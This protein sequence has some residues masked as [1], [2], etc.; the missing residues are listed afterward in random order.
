VQSCGANINHN[1]SRRQIRVPRNN[2]M[3]V[4]SQL[5]FAGRRIII[6]HQII[7]REFIL[8]YNLSLSTI[9]HSCA[10]DFRYAARDGLYPFKTLQSIIC[11]GKNL[12]SSDSS[13]RKGAHIAA[14]I[15]ELNS[16]IAAAQ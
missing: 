5:Y 9:P 11:R 2:G 13:V 3:L 7:Q 16:P 4:I 8:L 14:H 6:A 15:T 12:I 1:I 10:S